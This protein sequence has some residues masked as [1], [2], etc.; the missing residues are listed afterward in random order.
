MAYPEILEEN[1]QKEFTETYIRK[2]DGRQQP[3]MCYYHTKNFGFPI[4]MHVHSFY[5]INIVVRG[6]GRHYIENRSF[7]TMIGNVY[8]IPPHIRHG[9]YCEDNSLE[10]F[11]LLLGGSIIERYQRELSQLA[12]YSILFEIEPF[13]RIGGSQKRL[14][15]TLSPKELQNLS[16]FMDELM[17]SSINFQNEMLT[18]FKALH[19]IG[20]LSQ[21]MLEAYNTP[22]S[23]VDRKS[24]V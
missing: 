19:F 12:G 9:Y 4:G 15:L 16:A 8:V 20:L 18:T 1:E 24:V 7:D 23:S 2:D 11:H 6:N 21:L 17:A 5:E 22:E 10:I 13:I 14:F 3:L